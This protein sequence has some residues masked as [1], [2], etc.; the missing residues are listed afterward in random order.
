MSDFHE[1]FESTPPI[2]K[3]YL[4]QYYGGKMPDPM[5]HKTKT[6]TDMKP[7][8]TEAPQNKGPRK[9]TPEST[10]QVAK[11]PGPVPA[12]DLSALSDAELATELRKRGYTLIASKEITRV[13]EL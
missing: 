7:T 4:P 13:I 5:A 1:I 11:A 6:Q 9:W 2:P 3:R 10:P 12:A 8:K